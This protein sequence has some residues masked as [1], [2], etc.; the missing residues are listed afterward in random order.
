MNHQAL[1]SA[2]ALDQMSV[3]DF[4]SVW[5]TIMGEPPAVML[6]SRAEIIRILTEAFQARSICAGQQVQVT[7]QII[8]RSCTA[9]D[10]RRVLTGSLD[11]L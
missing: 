7:T 1:P 10:A 9:D 5:H 6:E 8:D 3:I 2:E 11:R 4:V